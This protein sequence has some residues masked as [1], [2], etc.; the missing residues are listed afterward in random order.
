M[1][2]VKIIFNG[3]QHQ[4]QFLSKAITIELK[5]H[6]IDNFNKST[7]II[8]QA[9]ITAFCIYNQPI[10]RRNRVC[11]LCEYDNMDDVL[12]Y[13]NIFGKMINLHTKCF[14]DNFERR[15]NSKYQTLSIFSNEDYHCLKTWDCYI[16]YNSFKLHVIQYYEHDVVSYLQLDQLDQVLRCYRG[17]T[18]LIYKSLYTEGSKQLFITKHLPTILLIKKIITH[19]DIQYYM[20]NIYINLLV[21]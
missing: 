3:N 10:K 19:T 1:D 11:W 15:R 6:D 8:N 12:E 16:V 5:S 14:D 21:H 7:N 2:I 17:N 18:L 20:L 13:E 4:I 9:M